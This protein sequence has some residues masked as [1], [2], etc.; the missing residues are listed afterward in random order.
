[1][2]APA[3]REPSFQ[4]RRKE[5]FESVALRNYILVDVAVLGLAG[6]IGGMV[7]YWFIGISTKVRGWPGVLAFA[8]ASFLG[9]S[10]RSAAGPGAGGL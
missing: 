7:G 2:R 8:L 9:L 3:R 6:L 1:L 10:V 5:T 4:S